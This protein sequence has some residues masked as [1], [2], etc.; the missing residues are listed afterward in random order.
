[1]GIVFMF[2]WFVF[3]I[4]TFVSL[5]IWLIKRK[6][7]HG[8]RTLIFF[9]LAALCMVAA[10]NDQDFVDGLSQDSTATTAKTEEPEVDPKQQG[11]EFDERA[12]KDFLQLY[13]THNK[14]VKAVSLYAED[15][16]SKL[17]FYDFCKEAEQW[18]A[19][20][21]LSFKYGKTDDEKEYLRTFETFA[22]A[23]QQAAKSLMKYL[24][25]NSMK[26]LSKAKENIERGKQASVIIA[27]N[28]VVLLRKLNFTEE[29][30]Q[31]TIEQVTADLEEIDKKL[32][33]Q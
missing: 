24:D 16:I 20:K 32:A 26:D 27:K 14:L 28:R 7:K 18:F 31:K 15:R 3:A 29:E 12:W 22:L 25:S 10:I 19:N 11:I 17:D 21:S 2:L 4:L 33:E 13:E 9:V 8:L 6:K 5:I 23:D 30:I 1:M